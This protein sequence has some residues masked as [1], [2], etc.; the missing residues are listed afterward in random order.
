MSGRVWLLKNW[1][2]DALRHESHLI[3]FVHALLDIPNLAYAGAQC[4]AGLLRCL[5]C[6]HPRFEY[7]TLQRLLLSRAQRLKTSHFRSLPP[8]THATASMA[9][10]PIDGLLSPTWGTAGPSE[11][12]RQAA[13]M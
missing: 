13:K 2:K 5:T 10:K 9:S 11:K 6:Q 1:G 8:I 4:L 12:L 3:Q 7:S